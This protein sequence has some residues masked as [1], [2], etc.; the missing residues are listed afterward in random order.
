M[1]VLWVL[2]VGLIFAGVGALLLGIVGIWALIDAFR[3]PA[4]LGTSTAGLLVSWET[5]PED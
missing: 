4:G 5:P 3:I 2:G 1:L